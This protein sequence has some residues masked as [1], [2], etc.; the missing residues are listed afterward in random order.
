MRHAGPT[1]REIGVRTAFNLLGPLTNP[2]GAT[3][4]V[5]GVGDAAAAPRLAE[6]AQR[7]GTERTLVVHGAGVD[8][9]P[10][11]GTGV[12]LD[13]TPD[14]IDRRTVDVARAGRARA[15]PVRSNDAL[16]GGHARTRTRRSSKRSSGGRP[17]HG[18]TS[19]CS[20]RRRRSSPPV[21]PT[22]LAPMASRPPPAPS[23]TAGP[24]RCSARLRA[25]R[26]VADAARAAAAEA[27]AAAATAEGAR[28]DRRDTATGSA[29]SDRGRPR[30]GRPAGSSPRS[31]PGGSPTSS[32]S[33]R[34]IGPSRSSPGRCRRARRRATSSSVWPGPGL[35]LI[36]EVKRRSP[37]AGAIAEPDDDPR[38]ARSRLRARRCERD[39]GPVRAA[40]VRGL[41]RRPH[42]RPG[43]GQPAGPGQGV[44]RRR[45]PAAAAASG[46]RRR[47]PPARRP[48]PGPPA[49]RARRRRARSRARAAR[50]GARRA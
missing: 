13:V 31:P 20:T 23:T 49:E 3:R 15:R 29:R 27:E 35:H 28:R 39:L 17:G 2:A 34:R 30:A 12:V 43:G 19:S 32:P 42:G 9:L 14:G 50:R 7:L 21:G 22:G 24:P 4:Q 10:L 8:E 18:A 41:D 40:L 45:P 16:A 38:R 48:P 44:R 1:R 37:S 33:W 6:V 47:R 36:A 26:V 11:D 25:E 5:L 46:R